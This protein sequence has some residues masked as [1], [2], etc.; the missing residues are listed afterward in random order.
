MSTLDIILSFIEQ[1]DGTVIG[2]SLKNMIDKG[3]NYKYICE[4]ADIEME[5]TED[6]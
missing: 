4:Y 5:E 3:T 6:E 2:Q 1:Y